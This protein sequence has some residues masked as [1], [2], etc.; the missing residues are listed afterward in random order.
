MP[1]SITV[2]NPAQTVTVTLTKVEHNKPIDDSM[3][4]KPVAK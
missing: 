3:F 1:F 4:S 2:V